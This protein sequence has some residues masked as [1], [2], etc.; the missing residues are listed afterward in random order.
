MVP[1]AGKQSGGRHR[2]I[3]AH[4][5]SA[6][7]WSLPLPSRGTRRPAGRPSSVCTPRCAFSRS[8]GTRSP[9]AATRASAHPRYSEVSPHQKSGNRPTERNPAPSCGTL[10]RR[11][12][13]AAPGPSGHH[14]SRRSHPP[15]LPCEVRMYPS[16]DTARSQ[17]AI[18]L[19]ETCDF[20][21]AVALLQEPLTLEER[22]LLT[23]L[24]LKN[25]A[26][27][28][29]SRHTGPSHQR[30]P[31]QRRPSGRFVFRSARDGLDHLQRQRSRNQRP[32]RPRP[33]LHRRPYRA[34]P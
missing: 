31:H 14:P 9:G 23:C 3:A 15:A 20:S 28:S 26:P 19:A 1:Q 5:H 32:A 7:S 8:A 17:Q 10:E 21:G 24:H 33:V 4:G 11:R 12:T 13:P 30:R 16:T 2:W 6:V 34:E 29:S 25:E 18:T 22:L 27:A